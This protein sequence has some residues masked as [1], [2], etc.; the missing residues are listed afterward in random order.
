MADAFSSLGNVL[1]GSNILP[2]C[3][4]AFEKWHA[5]VSKM[6]AGGADPSNP[7]TE[8]A[9]EE[10]VRDHVHAEVLFDPPTYNGTYTGKLPFRVILSTVGQVFGPSF[11]YHRQW[12]SNDGCEWALEF[13][14]SIAD[15]GKKI[16]GIDLVSLNADG[17][18]ISFRI[19]A[20]PPSGVGALRDEMFSRVPKAMEKMVA[21]SS[22]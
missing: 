19:L 4:A 9:F 18:I 7:E 1:G 12:L 6:M 5:C 17:Q 13:T 3:R 21:S 2:G 15:T 22:L 14:T 10:F 8:R 16:R 20:A 11:T